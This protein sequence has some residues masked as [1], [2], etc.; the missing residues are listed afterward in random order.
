MSVRSVPSGNSNPFASACSPATNSSLARVTEEA[1]LTNV[2]EVRHPIPDQLFSQFVQNWGA[3]ITK[4]HSGL[5]PSLD[6]TSDT[7]LTRSAVIRDLLLDPTRFPN[8]IRWSLAFA[9]TPRS[10]SVVMPFSSGICASDE[11]HGPQLEDPGLQAKRVQMWIRDV[12]RDVVKIGEVVK[13]YPIQTDNTRWIVNVRYLLR[14]LG[15]HLHVAL[16]GNRST[17]S[18][19][20][21]LLEAKLRGSGV[22]VDFRIKMR[23]VIVSIL[24][25]APQTESIP[26]LMVDPDFARHFLEDMRNL[27]SWKSFDSICL[28]N[29]QIWK[30]CSS[31]LESQPGLPTSSCLDHRTD[32]V[33][34]GRAISLL[35]NDLLVLAGIR[36]GV[37]VNYKQTGTQ[38]GVLVW[39]GSEA[40]YVA[41]RVSPFV[42]SSFANSLQRVVAGWKGYSPDALGLELKGRLA[43]AVKDVD[44]VRGA[45]QE[46]SKGERNQPVLVLVCCL[47][48]KAET[49]QQQLLDA[50]TG[51]GMED[52]GIQG[53]VN[54]YPGINS[55]RSAC[56][57]FDELLTQVEALREDTNQLI[58]RERSNVEPF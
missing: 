38:R 26:P 8:Y 35:M 45:V 48:Q 21:S 30:H 18:S 39:T 4:E 42:P 29:P 25:I 37:R 19:N 36:S 33:Q 28:G 54:T 27:S 50:R 5:F 11:Y 41:H 55:L 47:R 51:F 58:P 14:S 7:S 53:L 49:L 17:D 12:G 9:N 40:V 10:K 16:N 44:H 15:E 6:S 43:A 56:T 13:H 46:L 20:L 31:F 3:S 57:V 32:S 2:E 1:G 22:V 24:E 34:E 23:D 52:G